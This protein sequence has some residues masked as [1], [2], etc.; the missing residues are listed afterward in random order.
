MIGAH[1]TLISRKPW[2]VLE[3][4]ILP[5]LQPEAFYGELQRLRQAPKV[6]QAACPFHDDAETCLTI[7]PDRLSWHCT[8]GCGSGGPI[9]FMQRRVPGTSWVDAARELCRLAEVNAQIL[10]TWRDSWTEDDFIRHEEQEKRRNLLE[11]F[12]AFAQN[13]LLS[14]NGNQAR[15]YLVKRGFL[16]EKLG[17]LGFGMY[18]GPGAVREYLKQKGFNPD[19]AE[20]L[21]LF[22]SKWQN[23]VIGPWCDARGAIINIWGRH[24]GETPK[25]LRKF[26]YLT[27]PAPGSPLGGLDTPFNMDA[28]IRAGKRDLLLV[29]G[30]IKCL[31]PYSYG[32]EDPFPIASGGIISN[33][34]IDLLDNYLRQDGS[35]TICW[36]YDPQVYGTE[37]DRTLKTLKRLSGVRFKIHVIDPIMMAD[38]VSI[39]TKVDPDEYI[40]NHGGDGIGLGSFR[41]LLESRMHAYRYQARAIIKKHRTDERWSD[42]GLAAAIDEAIGFDSS[43]TDARKLP[44]LDRFFWSEVLE[45]TGANWRALEASRYAVRDKRTKEQ[46]QR[47]YEA[48]LTEAL[49]DL[50]A[51]NLDAA[52]S[53]LHDG[54]DKLRAEERLRIAE[55]TLPIA[56]EIMSHEERI[57]PWRGERLI[58]MRTASLPKLDEATLGM[59]GLILLEGAPGVG[60]TALGVQIGMDIVENNPNA[61]FLCLSM[62]MSRWEILSRIKCRLAQLDWQTFVFGSQPE[63][64]GSDREASFTKEELEQLETAER[65]LI[66]L[67]RRVMVLDERNFPSPSTEKVLAELAN[68]KA[69]TGATR[70]FILIDYLQLWPTAIHESARLDSDLKAEKWRLSAMKSLADACSNGAVMV[71][72]ADDEADH[73]DRHGANSHLSAHRHYH[74]PD[75]VMQLI[76]FSKA[77]LAARHGLDAASGAKDLVTKLD[78]MKEKGIAY[79][80]L[81]IPKGRDGVNRT[82][83]DLT[84]FYRRLSFKEKI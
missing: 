12:L 37:E 42:A 25:G 54:I 32:L 74:T 18:T 84:F 77:E 63:Q 5:R 31:L 72:W 70:A 28:A 83:I 8:A 59:H 38:N 82:E 35:L 22:L 11:A 27:R 80:K 57:E 17:E 71:I 73:G 14:S 13:L 79:D 2:E 81:L 23:R 78:E 56:A 36:D 40:Q 55:P 47:D 53:K 51:G 7:N 19:I 26:E 29:E 75:L 21:G 1:T 30:P 64:E 6:W 41:N 46:E 20:G 60:K 66:S 45:K 44:D 34:Q 4:D 52:K 9:Q 24:A 3:E 61:C 62:A 68:L 50:R 10:E 15:A 43:V 48:L 76:P 33:A 49:Q 16:E 69:S 67:G 58:G 65:K 39:T